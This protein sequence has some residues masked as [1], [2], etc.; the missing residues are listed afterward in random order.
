[1]ILDIPA[2]RE[3]GNKISAFFCD[4]MEHASDTLFNYGWDSG[5]CRVILSGAADSVGDILKA[6]YAAEF[7]E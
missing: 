4:R 3:K 6:Y 1:M 5:F 7:S 2:S